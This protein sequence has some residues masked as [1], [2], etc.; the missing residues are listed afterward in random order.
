MKET[1]DMNEAG[2][3]KETADMKPAGG[4]ERNP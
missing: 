3:M 2:D 1:A 4:M